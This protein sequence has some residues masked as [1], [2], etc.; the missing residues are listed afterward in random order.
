MA[1]AVRAVVGASKGLAVWRAG[2]LTRRVPGQRADS[3][4][5]PCHWPERRF[6][7][8][9]RVPGQR[10][11]LLATRRPW[12]ERRLAC[13]STSLASAPGVRAVSL[14]VSRRTLCGMPRCWRED[15]G[16]DACACGMRE[17]FQRTGAA[18][19][20]AQ[21]AWQ[22]AEG[23]YREPGTG[24]RIAD[25]GFPPP[26]TRHPTRDTRYRYPATDTDT[27]CPA[28]LP[29]PPHDRYRRPSRV[30]AASPLAVLNRMFFARQH[31]PSQGRELVARGRRIDSRLLQR[32]RANHGVTQRCWYTKRGR[33]RAEPENNRGQLAATP[34]TVASRPVASSR[35]S[36]PR[37]R[38]DSR[39]SGGHTNRDHKSTTR[40][41]E[42][43]PTT[44]TP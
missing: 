15:H 20:H 18:T 13:H 32:W 41:L 11:G 12:P 35:P 34:A 44:A 36:Q 25:S 2:Y 43:K 4:A 19:R 8:P 31:Q 24:Y 17:Y 14:A 9:C 10:A 16:L 5:T 23:E 3:F 38:L 28:G 21:L 22:C 6:L 26:D 40:H 37:S 30:A 7:F 33:P 39:Q 42:T 29:V 1:R 27:D